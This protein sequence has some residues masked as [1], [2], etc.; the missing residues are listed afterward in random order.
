MSVGPGAFLA[1]AAVL[2]A[3]GLYGAVARRGPLAVLMSLQMM[4][5]A[6]NLNIVTFTRFVTPAEQAGKLLPVFSLTVAVLH[7]GLGVALVS[8][9]SRRARSVQ[10]GSAGPAGAGER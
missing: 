8:G 5:I 9:A 10:R 2:F 3:A 7:L 1:L 6:V 4:A